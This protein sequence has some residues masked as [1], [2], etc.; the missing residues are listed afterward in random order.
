MYILFSE[1]LTFIK[2]ITACAG[3]YSNLLPFAICS[4]MIFIDKF[5]LTAHT[6]KEFIQIYSTLQSA[7]ALSLFT[8]YHTG[9]FCC[10]YFLKKKS[11]VYVMRLS[12]T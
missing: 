11:S 12:S 9:G 5:P 1:M 3:I 7:F 6:R 10:F 8:K 2:C 4:V